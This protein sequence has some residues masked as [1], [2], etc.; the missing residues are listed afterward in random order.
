MA[1]NSRERKGP[2]YHEEVNEKGREGEKAKAHVCVV[3]QANCEKL[4]L[5]ASSLGVL[6]RE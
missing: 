5:Y 2:F 3:F 4:V 1:R 6:R